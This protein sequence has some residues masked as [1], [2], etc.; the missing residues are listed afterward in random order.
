MPASTHFD[1]ARILRDHSAA[2]PKV[3]P[4]YC[5]SDAST[6]NSLEC[7]A[8]I[9]IEQDERIASMTVALREAREGLT[10]LVKQSRGLISYDGC[11]AA[12]G[13]SALALVNAALAP[14]RPFAGFS[15]PPAEL[16]QRAPEPAR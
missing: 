15:R 3:P 8:A 7:A 9:L 10:R 6:R 2:L 12:R 11:N 16:T 13:E 5:V 14:A 1:L 4:V